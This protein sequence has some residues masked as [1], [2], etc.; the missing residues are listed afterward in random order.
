MNEWLPKSSTS[1]D[2][3]ERKKLRND[4]AHPEEDQERIRDEQIEELVVVVP[5]TVIDPWAV[6]VH[7]QNTPVAHAAVVTAIRLDFDALAAPSA[8]AI[9]LFLD[10]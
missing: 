2:A 10:G 8:T 6:M 7:L 9:K 1:G 4:V 3:T 5:H